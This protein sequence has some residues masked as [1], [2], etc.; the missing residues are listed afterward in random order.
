MRASHPAPPAAEQRQSPTHPPIRKA[1]RGDVPDLALALA[2]A[3]HRDPVWSF[4]LPDEAHRERA[5]RR[6]F[7]IELRDV[8][9]PHDTTWT[10]EGALG[11]ILCT[12]P[13]SWR[14]SPVTMVVRG[15]TFLRAFGR[16]LPRALRALARLE[17]VHPRAPHY[18]I[19]YAG[20]PPEWQGHG[21]GS[22]LVSRLLERC[23]AERSPAYLEATSERAAAFYHRHGF[24]VTQEVELK[25]GPPLWLMW[26]D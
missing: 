22:A 9:L 7:T 17:R 20:L 8:V 26:R 16:H 18:Y 21:L 11:A 3:Y 4:L 2:R 15:P 24:A 12:P 23:D 5:L 19:A 6:F 14:V 13:G 1:T 25:N 10:T